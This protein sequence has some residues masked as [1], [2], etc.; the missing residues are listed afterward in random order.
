[1]GSSLVFLL[2]VLSFADAPRIRAVEVRCNEVFETNR[3]KRSFWFFRLANRLHI[4]TR[5]EQ[6]R[7]ELLFA[8]GDLL[9]AEAVGQTERNLRAF[10]YLRDARI[11]TVPAGDGVV[12]VRVETWDSWSTQ[13][14]LGIATAGDVVVWSA[15]ISEKNLL[16]RG[17]HLELSYRSDID[18]DSGTLYYRDGRVLGSRIATALTLSNR[19]DG[20]LADLGVARPF[21]ALSTPWAFAARIS[22]FDQLDPLYAAG[23]KVQ[24]LRHVRQFGDVELARAVKR[25]RSSALRFHGGYRHVEDE[26]GTDRRDFGIARIGLSFRRHDFL[27]V[28]HVNNFE[29]ADDFNLGDEASAFVGLSTPALGG[30]P[31]QVLFFFVEERRGRSLG[32]EHFI[33]ARATW[34]ARRRHGDLEQNVASFEIDY[35]NKLAPRRLLA[36]SVQ[37]VY[38]SNLDPEF[39]LSRGAESGLRGY[40]VRQFTGSRSLL[41][42]AEK[43]FFIA[44]DVARIAS[45][46][47]AAFFDAGYAWPEG[48]RL[49]LADLKSDV[50]V[51]L[52]IGRNRLASRRGL[53]FDLAYALQPLT[54]RSP[55]LFSV[56]SRIGF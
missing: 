37:L 48:E 36:A 6:V 35:Y 18:R 14:E 45:I 50:G 28:T 2:G 38:G 15:G 12:D 5:E 54:G 26:V 29:V 1:M 39:Q 23:E 3:E 46:G 31:G 24:E 42:T 9:D 8:E 47:L 49:R 4:L 51:G 17:K 25:S 30:E 19:S 16:G 40:P 44:D 10:P 34:Q 53:R 7:Q 55:W 22:G 13:L 33:Q 41:L 21:F 43:R 32:R 11:S 20:R 27:K 52:L 56:G